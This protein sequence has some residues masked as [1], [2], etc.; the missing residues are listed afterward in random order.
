MRDDQKQFVYKAEQSVSF[1]KNSVAFSSYT[2]IQHFTDKITN[3]RWFQNRWDIYPTRIKKLHG[4]CRF[5]YYESSV[6]YLPKWALHKWV[7]CHELAHAVQP[8]YTEFHG[9]DFCND[10][11]ELV[12]YV[13]NKKAR[14]ELKKAFLKNDVCI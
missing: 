2:D 12:S 5:A 13:F 6:I 3:S 11:L 9:P 4:N 7:I 1:V 10:Y 8:P 14:I